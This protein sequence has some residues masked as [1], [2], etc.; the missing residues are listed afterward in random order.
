M[1]V[2]LQDVPRNAYDSAI[3][4]L[5]NI[6][7]FGARALNSVATADFYLY[8]NILDNSL[9]LLN[10]K[11]STE[12][13]TADIRAAFEGLSDSDSRHVVADLLAKVR[14]LKLNDL[15]LS[16]DPED[17][18]TFHLEGEDVAQIFK[19]SSEM[20]KI[21]NESD[22]FQENHKRR[23]NMR[24]SKIESEVH[25]SRGSFDTV[26]AGVTEIGEV[27]GKFGKDVKPLVDRMS[28][29]KKITEKNMG[30]IPQIEGPDEPR[31]LPAPDDPDTPE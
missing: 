14:T 10:G 23:L 28:E 6:L 19:L 26:L 11:Y 16:D 27:F 22:K 1:T 20:K 3:Y 4:C 2:N 24:I 15:V 5:E 29:I 12:F 31:Q 30:D 8:L 25:R 21:V 9:E 17:E 7:A 18:L 13:S